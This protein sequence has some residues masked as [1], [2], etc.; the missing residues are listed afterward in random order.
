MIPLRSFALGLRV[1]IATLL[2]LAARLLAW[3]G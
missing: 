2:P 1:L 3:L